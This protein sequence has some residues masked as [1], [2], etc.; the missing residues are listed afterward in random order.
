M[1]YHIRAKRMVGGLE[2][3]LGWLPG[4]FSSVRDVLLWRSFV[5]CGVRADVRFC[6]KRGK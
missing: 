6:I 5:S 3:R 4:A 1:W 2:I